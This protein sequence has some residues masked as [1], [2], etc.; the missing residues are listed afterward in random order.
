[1]VNLEFDLQVIIVSGMKQV[2]RVIIGLAT[3]LSAAVAEHHV[4]VFLTMEGAAF[5]NPE[6]GKLNYINGFESVQKYFDLLLEEGAHIEVCSTCVDNYCLTEKLGS[7]RF[8]NPK[9]NLAGLSTAGIRA[10]QVK[11]LVF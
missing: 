2:E 3:A 8:I 4:V 6:E 11:T 1:M 9:M 5:A 7:V 10:A